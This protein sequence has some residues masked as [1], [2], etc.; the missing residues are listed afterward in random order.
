M[1]VAGDASGDPNLL[2]LAKKY[3]KIKYQKPGKVYL[4]LVHR[5]DRPVSGVVFLARTSKAAARLFE[6]FRSGSVQ[7]VYLAWVDGVLESSSGIVT[8]LIVKDSRRNV[9]RTTAAEETGAKAATL[10]Y[11]LLKTSRGKSLLE[12]RPRTGRPHQIRVQLAA[13]GTPI[14]GDVKYGARPSPTG[15]LALHAAELTFRHPVRDESITIRSPAPPDWE[16]R[17]RP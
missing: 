17:I 7:K 8:D 6:Q 14:V 10:E 5:L 2:D 16:K 13:R 15:R 9:S 1:P 4:G 12:I 3:I 11:R